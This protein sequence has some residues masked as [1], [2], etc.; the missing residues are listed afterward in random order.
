MAHEQRQLEF[1]ISDNSQALV[2]WVLGG[3]H[4][5]VTDKQVRRLFALGKVE[6]TL[7]T[8]AAKAGM[9]EPSARSV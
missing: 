9:G 6:T 8:A 1:P 4:N 7:E 3:T 2:F 5:L